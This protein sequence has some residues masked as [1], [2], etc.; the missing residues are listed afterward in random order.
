MTAHCRD[1]TFPRGILPHHLCNSCG[2]PAHTSG[3]NCLGAPEPEEVEKLRALG[4]QYRHGGCT[5]CEFLGRARLPSPS[6]RGLGMVD[7]DYDLWYCPRT[8]TAGRSVLARFG[9]EPQ[10]FYAERYPLSTTRDYQPALREAARLASRR[11]YL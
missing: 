7:R 11:G 9:E 3:A 4:A 8:D 2:Q 5:A 1:R 10:D 6:L